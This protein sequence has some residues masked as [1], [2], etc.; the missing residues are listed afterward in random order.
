MFFQGITTNVRFAVFPRSVRKFLPL[1]SEQQIKTVILNMLAHADLA[2][3]L[4]QCLPDDYE[5][6][7][8][9]GQILELPLE[10]LNLCHCFMRFLKITGGKNI[11]LLLRKVIHPM[12]SVSSFY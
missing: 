4:L 11:R 12:V 2:I 7:Y 6:H 5:D 3:A 8:I 9:R 1:C 10:Q